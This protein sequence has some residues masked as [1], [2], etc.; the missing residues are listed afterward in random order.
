MK[1]TAII[2]FIGVTLFAGASLSQAARTLNRC[3]LAREMA[4]RG[5]PRDQLAR[6]A[7]IAQRESD[8]RTWVVG[9]ANSDGS[10]DYGIF[11]L[12]NL[13]WC[14]PANGRF[15]HNGCR[16]SCNDLLTD[17]I[18]N[19]VRCAQR[20]LSEQGWGAWSTWR[21]CNGNL[22]SINDCF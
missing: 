13:Y 8:Y 3:T 21:F 4:A 10:N 2:L 11:Q 6:W 1:A 17:D 22:P 12:N 7:C 18:T 19:S 14:Q 15:S 5:V 20:V 9:P 16:I